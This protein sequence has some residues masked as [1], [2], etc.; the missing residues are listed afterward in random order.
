MNLTMQKVIITAMAI[1]SLLGFSGSK[2]SSGPEDWS[3]RQVDKWFNSKKWTA[4][5]NIE[6]DRSINRREFA[7]SYFRHKE[8]WEKAFI[9]LAG[10]DLK[11]LENKR[12]DIDGDNLYASVSEY[13]TKDEK[14][15]NFEAHRKYIDIQY[16]ISSSENMNVVPLK[17]AGE[18]VT[19]YDN[20]R[21]IEFMK[22]VASRNIAATQKNFFIFFPSDAHRPGIREKEPVNVKKIV[23]KLSA[24]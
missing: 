2:N 7:I 20:T 22:P 14:T 16:V 12:Y 13:P 17:N 9:F 3:D 21:D 8:R 24:E 15:T 6:P 18:V 10:T 4:G 11:K 1:L 23:I 5:W 19:P